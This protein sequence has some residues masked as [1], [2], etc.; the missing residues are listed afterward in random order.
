M[1]EQRQKLTTKMRVQTPEKKF[2]EVLAAL[3]GMLVYLPSEP[4][5]YT[6]MVLREHMRV[7][8]MMDAYARSIG[9]EAKYYRL[10]VKCLRA[11]DGKTT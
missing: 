8:R 4:E 6:Q 11:D 1:K 7:A 3:Q 10:L 2:A 9:V 5:W